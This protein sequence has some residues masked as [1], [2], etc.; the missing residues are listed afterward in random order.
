MPKGRPEANTCCGEGAWEDEEAEDEGMPICVY[1]QSTGSS[2]SGPKSFPKSST[3][4]L[5]CC[6]DSNYIPPGV[7]SSDVP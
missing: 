4:K 2:G 6:C 1:R 5:H 3:T 7:R